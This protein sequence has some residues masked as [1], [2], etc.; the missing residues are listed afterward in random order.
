MDK[1]IFARNKVITA[2]TGGAV[3]FLLYLTSIYNY[4][5]FH[6]FVEVFSILVAWGIFII[7]W[8]SRQFIDWL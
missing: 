4:I 3:L 6:S 7:A 2:T 5:L 8:N 1:S